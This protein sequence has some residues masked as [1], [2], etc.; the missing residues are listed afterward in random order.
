MSFKYVCVRVCV[1]GGGGQFQIYKRVQRV[2][3]CAHA[4]ERA[5]MHVRA[6]KQTR[7]LEIA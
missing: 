5:H 3:M 6:H 4:R 2:D 7:T 1:C